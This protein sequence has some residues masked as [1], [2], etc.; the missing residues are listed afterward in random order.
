MALAKNN[1]ALLELIDGFKQCVRPGQKR[2]VL[3]G[4]Q[5][6]Q[7]SPDPPATR[8]A[9]RFEELDQRVLFL[10]VA[11]VQFLAVSLRLGQMLGVLPGSIDLG[12]VG[13]A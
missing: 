4:H 9:A 6:Q 7:G 5:E 3:I 11:C 1:E 13:L 12:G 2:K 10:V 8:V